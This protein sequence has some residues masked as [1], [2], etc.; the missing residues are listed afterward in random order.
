MLELS[1]FTASGQENEFTVYERYIEKEVAKVETTLLSMDEGKAVYEISV[2]YAKKGNRQ[3]GQ[4][5]LLLLTYAGEKLEVLIDGYKMNDHFYSGQEV[6][7]SLGYFGFPELLTVVI[8][9]LNERDDIFME[10]R[11]EFHE[12]KACALKEVKVV[13]EYR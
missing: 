3:D 7:I 12:G 10:H 13:E 11:P 1:G 6:P 2:C 9:P 4:D 5:V 8:D